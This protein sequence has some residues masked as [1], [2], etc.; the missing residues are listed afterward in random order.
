MNIFQDPTVEEEKEIGEFF[1]LIPIGESCEQARDLTEIGFF[2]GLPDLDE[3][4]DWP[5]TRSGIP[6]TFLAQIDLSRVSKTLWDGKGPRDG[7]LLFFAS[8]DWLPVESLQGSPDCTVI[9]CRTGKPTS[10][11]KDAPNVSEYLSHQINRSNDQ[12]ECKLVLPR[13]SVVRNKASRKGE[14][15]YMDGVPLDHQSR[16]GDI[17]FIG[18][19]FF[20]K[21]TPHLSISGIPHVKIEKPPFDKKNYLLLQIANTASLGWRYEGP[22]IIF[23]G[24]PG[25][26]LEAGRFDRAAGFEVSD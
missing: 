1:S 8:R 13:S 18:R 24:I 6:M 25:A 2:G 9:H 19:T 26:D 16:S 21:P 14:G 17:F 15:N 22:Y 4:V 5:R 23:F 11:P 3:N 20:E 12:M 7:M 10:P